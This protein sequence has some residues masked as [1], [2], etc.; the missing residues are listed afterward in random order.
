MFAQQLSLWLASRKV[1]YAWI[2]A[3]TTFLTMLVTSAALGLPGALLQPLHQEFGWTTESISSALALRFVLFGLLGPFA[4]I[5]MS[6]FGVR[7]VVVTALTM[8]ASGL[9]LAT[10]ATELWQ[11]FVLWG[12]VLGVGSGLTALVLGA[13]VASR[14]F[15]ARRGLVIG[16][17]TAS[18]ATGQLLFL[19]LAAWLIE[20]AGWRMA[21]IPAFIAC[22]VVGVL[23]WCFLR[24]HPQDVGLVSFGEP[25][26]DVVT[27]RTYP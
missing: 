27:P 24:N 20:N 22:A 10:L 25:V 6:R 14:W 8:V 3:A 13:V 26:P 1:H 15:S 17:L 21:V 4:A 7:A 11:L 12:V 9:A 19:P 2:I 5:F 18:S 23:A 16:L